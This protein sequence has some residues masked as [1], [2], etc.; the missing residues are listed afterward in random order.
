[1]GTATVLFLIIGGIGVLLLVLGLLGVELFDIDSFVPLEAVAAA[2]ATF[3]FG[4]AIASTALGGRTIPAL[5]AA[6][7]IG[8]AAAVPASWLALRLARAAQRMPTDATPQRDDL[9]GLL[10]VVVSP[11]P[12]QGY[13]EVRVTLGGQ[14][15]K[16]HATADDPIPLGAEVFVI[17]APSDTSVLV[18]AISPHD[19]ALD[20]PALNPPA[21]GSPAPGSPAPG[22][23][24]PDPPASNS[25]ALG[26]PAP[27]PPGSG[28]PA[29]SPPASGSPGPNA[30]DS[31]SLAPDP[32][33]SNA[34]GSGS[35][36][37]DLPAPDSD[38]R[39]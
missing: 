29:L 4:A 18:A 38:E 34:P 13:G 16:V 22:S 15:V 32:P 11:I 27:D 21:S 14:P 19:P 6:A 36:A 17:S 39:P 8:V 24:A 3:G 31:G 9:L 28:S 1:M 5:I 26:S 37:P 35:R 20:S 7:G 30:P 25:P 33:G 10:G 12:R 23:P 2:M